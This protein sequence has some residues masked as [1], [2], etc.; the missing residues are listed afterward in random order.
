MDTILLRTSTEVDNETGQITG[1]KGVKVSVNHI[2]TVIIRAQGAKRFFGN[3][4]RLFGATLVGVGIWIKDDAETE[5][6]GAAA[7]GTGIAFGGQKMIYKR[8]KMSDSKFKVYNG[9]K[10]RP[11]HIVNK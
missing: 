5:L 10:L 2:E 4:F 9:Q 7:F 3:A 1:F 8:F 11:W 6:L